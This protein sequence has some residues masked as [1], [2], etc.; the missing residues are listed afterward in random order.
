MATDTNNTFIVLRQGAITD[1][2]GNPV[3]PVTMPEA[4]S[5]VAIDMQ[6]PMIL[7]FDLD[8][9]MKVLIIYFSEVINTTTFNTMALS[10][11]NHVS[12]PTFEL[13]IMNGTY[14][15]DFTDTLYFGLLPADLVVLK[16]SPQIARSPNT[17]FLAVGTASVYDLRGFNATGYPM[18][19]ALRVSILTQDTAAPRITEFDLDLY[20]NTITIRFDEAIDVSSFDPTKVVI[21]NRVRDSTSSY[22]LTGGSYSD[23]SAQEIVINLTPSDVNNIKLFNDL[24]TNRSNCFLTGDSILVTD[25]LGNVYNASVYSTNVAP[26]RGFVLDIVDPEYVAFNSLD[27][28]TGLLQIEFTEPVLSYAV[29]FNELTIQSWYTN[30]P[31]DP[32]FVSF[33]LTGGQARVNGAILIIELN[34][35]DLNFIKNDNELC[36]RRQ[37]CWITFTGGFVQDV[38]T[39]PVVPLDEPSVFTS[40][41][42]VQTLI[43]DTS[44][45]V[46]V[47]VLLD[48]DENNITLV[49]DEVVDLDSFEPTS[50]TFTTGQ[51]STITYTL[52]AADVASTN[53][54]ASP[55]LT[56]ILTAETINRLKSMGI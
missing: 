11:Q 12:N 27:L 46:L 49:F 18:T 13:D 14:S 43:G 31:V 38:T 10:L 6:R 5:S 55:V 50:L 44:D 54:G 48:F 19:A 3:V 40:N 21:Q 52:E 47:D 26:V 15:T 34:D 1:T 35:V 45:P 20:N 24:C 30:D 4:A 23:L 41:Q 9:S 17:T 37:S 2:S 29:Q 25:I 36:N 53:T 51:N 32:N 42:H 8:L 56:A 22:P 7:G 28:N 33:Q 16:T 39:N